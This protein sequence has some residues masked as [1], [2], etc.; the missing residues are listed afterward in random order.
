MPA[1]HSYLLTKGGEQAA[2]RILR[3]LLIS[4]LRGIV[5]SKN[6]PEK[7]LDLYGIDC[8]IVWIQGKEVQQDARAITVEPQRLTRIYTLIADFVRNN[9]GGVAML[10]GLD[11]LI[12]ENDFESVMKAVQLMNETVAISGSI[13]LV[14]VNPTRISEKE[15]SFLEREMRIL[16]VN[17]MGLESF[18]GDNSF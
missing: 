17:S 7:I 1:G 18:E 10:D 12:V 3:N 14:P 15:L 9:A 13:L 2:Y 5:L 6:N 16:D 11:Y 4:G 8:P